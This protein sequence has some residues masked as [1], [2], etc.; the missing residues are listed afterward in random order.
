MGLGLP[1]AAYLLI[2]RES[3]RGKF[4]EAAQ[5]SELALGEPREV[6]FERTR[7]D[8]WRTFQ[9]K[10][11][12]WVVRTGEK[13]VV[14]YAPQCTHLGCA[15]HWE[16]QRHEF[17]CPCHESRFS[18]DGKVMGGPAARPLDRYVTRIEDQKLLIGTDIRKA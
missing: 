8:G 2:T 10:G 12:A 18:I 9:E 16:G 7:V 4:V 3:K 1:A 11:I 5:L 15:Y 6:T 13:Q 14:A 17:V